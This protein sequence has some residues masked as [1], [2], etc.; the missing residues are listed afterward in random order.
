MLAALLVEIGMARQP[1][2]QTLPAQPPGPAQRG[3]AADAAPPAGQRA[4]PER[5]EP[6]VRAA[7]HRALPRLQGSAVSFVG[8]RTCVSCHHN[9]LPI[10]TLRLAR[11]RGVA[12]DDAALETI[13]RTTF[14]ELRGPDA[15][16]DAVQGVNVSDPTPNDSYLLM[17]AHA[18]GVPATTV[19]AVYANRLARWQRGDHWQTS[20]FR[21]PHS[22][23]AFTATATAIRAMAAYMPAERAAERTEATRRAAAWL[24]ASRPRSTE[25]AAFRLFG[26]AWADAAA[27]TREGAIRDLL[28]LQASSGGWPTR[29]GYDADAYSTGESL[30]ALHQAGVPASHAAWQR[31]MAFLL[32][33]QARDGTWRV[34]TR[35]L[36]P[37]TVSPPYFHADFPYQADEFLS[38]AGT[39]WAVMALLSALPP[40]DVPRVAPAPAGDASRNDETPPW[41]RTALFGTSS[42]LKS[43]LDDGLPPEAATKNGTTLLMAV[44]PDGDKVA[45]LLARG[46]RADARATSGV[47]AVTVASTYRGTAAAIA[48]LLDAGALPEPPSDVRLRHTPLGYASMTG[49]EEVV[50]LLLDR[51]AGGLTTALPEA[52][53]FNQPGVARLLIER[54]ARVQ[55]QESSGVTLL[56]WA[57]IT[58]RPAMVPLLIGAGANPDAVD[59]HGFSPLMYAAT[60]DHG[61]TAVLDAL[62]EAGADR[63]IRNRQGRTPLQQ[64]EHLRLREI[65]SRLRAKQVG[66]TK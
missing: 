42:E 19:T 58:N 64:A 31:G 53:T 48:R 39:S 5:S 20:D 21:P 29:G 54:G 4:S 61:D 7:I 57:V 52:I 6:Q 36:S 45:L 12:I 28:A 13:E 66:A 34:R 37:A 38:Y 17:A 26:L 1:M 55:V 62:L 33:T 18:A 50:R 43:L 60:I 23:S 65:A 56:H 63:T 51:G 8:K 16:D 44:A 22:S 46:A 3:Q 9:V 30:V 24:A 27:P 47:D 41:M 35:M 49:D 11:Q 2:R 59:K 15:L 40:V 14:R 25:D 10:V 32:R